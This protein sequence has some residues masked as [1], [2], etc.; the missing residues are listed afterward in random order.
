MHPQLYDYASI[1]DQKPYDELYN[2]SLLD[3]DI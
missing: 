3:S 2:S 1:I